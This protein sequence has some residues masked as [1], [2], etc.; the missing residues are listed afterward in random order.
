M[1]RKLTCAMFVMVV[2]IGVA[3]AEEYTATLTKVDGN[4][5]T[6]QKYKAGKKGMKGEKD[7]DPITITVAKDAKIANGKGLGKGKFEAGDAI[8]GGLKAEVLTKATEDKGVA[9]HVTTDADNK[10]VTQLLVVGK[11]KAAQ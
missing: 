11:K 3:V 8:E 1:I 7:G 2:A 9:V 5:I 10:N 6:V 4:K